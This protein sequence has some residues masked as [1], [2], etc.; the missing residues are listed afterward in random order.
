MCRSVQCRR[1]TEQHPRPTP[2][3]H[4]RWRRRYGST[5]SDPMQYRLVFRA[6]VLA[7]IRETG[8][9]WW[10]HFTTETVGNIS[11]VSCGKA[12]APGLPL[13]FNGSILTHHEQEKDHERSVIS[14][15]DRYW[16]VRHECLGTAQI[17]RN[18]V[19]EWLM[20]EFALPAKENRSQRRCRKSGHVR[21]CQN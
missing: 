1:N 3:A 9:G 4:Q 20:C 15:C 17:R 18:N 5:V 13:S 21:R 12:F 6:H 19:T 7:D 2:C 11:F 8:A 14:S 16:M 10:I